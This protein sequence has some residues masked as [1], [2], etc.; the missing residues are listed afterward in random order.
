M[1]AQ[2][3]EFWTQLQEA[4][5]FTTTDMDWQK[6]WK[7][8]MFNGELVTDFDEAVK[9][10]RAVWSHKGVGLATFKQMSMNNAEWDN[11]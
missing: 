10:V 9:L 5:F 1:K 3:T 6:E 2:T 8:L 4:V 7:P 11:F